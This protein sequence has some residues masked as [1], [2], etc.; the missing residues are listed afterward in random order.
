MKTDALLVN[1]SR[2][3]LVE[4]DALSAALTSGRPGFAALDVFENEP[5][6]NDFALRSRENVLL[7]PHL[8]Y[9]ERDS[10]ELYFGTAFQNINDFCQR[11]N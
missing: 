1:T 5:L 2:A 11:E 10:Y 8:G 9:V 4:A 7:T 6:P 3:E